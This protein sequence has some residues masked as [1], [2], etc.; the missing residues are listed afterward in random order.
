MQSATI[1]ANPLMSVGL[2]PPELYSHFIEHLG[3]CI[4]DGIWAED[5]EI[6]SERGMRAFTLT[7]LENIGPNVIRWPGGCF[8][9]QYH[10][11]DGV[12]DAKD[13][14]KVQNI[15]WGGWEPNTF[16]THEFI[17]FCRAV[18]STPYFCGNV[19]TGSVTEMVEWVQYCNYKDERLSVVRE[20]RQNGSK[21]PFP[22]R[23]WG[24]GNENWGCGG[25]M[26]PEVYGSQF[27]QYATY[28][29]KLDTDIDL[30]AVGHTAEWNRRLMKILVE[31]GHGSQSPLPDHLSLHRYF[32]LER[33]TFE[34]SEQEYYELVAEAGLIEDDIVKA[35]GLLKQYENPEN[36]IGIIIDEWGVW[37][38]G[39]AVPETGLRQRN[40]VRDAV[41]AASCLDVFNSWSNRVTMTNI[42]Q[43]INVLQC[44]IETDGPDAWTTPTYEVFRMY[45]DHVG[46]NSL[47]TII[48]SPLLPIEGFVGG[49]PQALTSSCSLSE[50]GMQAVFTV[51]NRH[52]TETM[53]CSLILQDKSM[54]RAAARALTGFSLEQENSPLESIV[55][56]SQHPVEL[57]DGCVVIQLGPTS[58]AVISVDL[59]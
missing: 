38:R 9:D 28:L 19:G 14:S 47:K 13:R 2:I 29:N 7:A 37:D 54:V 42:A 8:A 33:Q 46:N 48:D 41:I 15:W 56:V 25:S 27:R 26:T 11:R 35:D 59:S 49:F 5:T 3:E 1:T 6:E 55:N 24:V 52:A 10:W 22:V 16:G 20:R 51:T 23:Y 50:D 39:R 12:G 40:T 43:T 36:P 34:Y 17:D 44:L 45:K 4:Y 53:E 57:K 21:D 32:S 31:K 18:G 58:V 30:I